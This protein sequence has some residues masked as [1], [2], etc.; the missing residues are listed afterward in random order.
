MY[1]C[2]CKHLHERTHYSRTSYGRKRS[3][4]DALHP[5]ARARSHLHKMRTALFALPK[6]V[7][8]FGYIKHT[9]A[10]APHRWSYLRVCTMAMAAEHTHTHKHNKHA[11]TLKHSGGSNSSGS[12]QNARGRSTQAFTPNAI[13][14][15]NKRRQPSTTYTR[16]C[17]FVF[18][19]GEGNASCGCSTGALVQRTRP[20]TAATR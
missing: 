13:I 18:G 3:A 10:G 9:R 1:Y 2:I 6:C 14:M 16:A 11:H 5:P 19:G 12:I 20:T 4:L 15:P 8:M 17:V 7:C